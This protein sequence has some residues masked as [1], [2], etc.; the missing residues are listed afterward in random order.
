[1]CASAALAA[2]EARAEG[3]VGRRSAPIIGGYGSPEDPSVVQVTAP[4]HSAGDRGGCGGV[5]VAPNLVLT[6]RHCTADFENIV[7]ECDPTLPNGG[8]PDILAAA[9]AEEIRVYAGLAFVRDDGSDPNTPAP[10]AFGK[11]LY[12]SP[13]TAICGN[14]VAALLLDRE[15]TTLPRAPVRLGPSRV[16]EEVYAV[17]W[18][19]R[20]TRLG[21]P[22]PLQRRDGLQVL[23]L[24]PT[25]Y[26]R[27]PGFRPMPAIEGELM[28]GQVG[29]NGDSGSPL[30]AQGTNA[31]VGV[32][33]YILNVDPEKNTAKDLFEAFPWCG[34]G[35]T[36]YYHTIAGRDFVLQAFADSG[37]RPWLEGQPEPAPFGQPCATSDACDSGVCLAGSGEPYCSALCDA[38]GACPEGYACISVEGRALCGRD[39]GGAADGGGALDGG[40]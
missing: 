32:L 21:P 24:G 33:S 28:V 22:G 3:D 10:V 4:R 16:G 40:A 1:F 15:V 23:A 2:G 9:P 20:S 7:F 34:D 37:H 12:A 31:V 17:G 8:G 18:G 5:L 27:A 29:C 26:E 19:Q 38:A 35:A 6:A 13:S 25:R 11:K 14:D 39:G 30:R 36:T